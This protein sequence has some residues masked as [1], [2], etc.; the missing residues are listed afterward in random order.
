MWRKLGSR[1]GNAGKEGNCGFLM[2]AE[3]NRTSWES[4]RTAHGITELI[5]APTLDVAAC[6]ESSLL[7]LRWGG[8]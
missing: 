5:G 8:R 2:E 1:A 3:G 6:S 7:D 4:P